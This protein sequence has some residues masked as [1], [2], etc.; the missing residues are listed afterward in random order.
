MLKAQ[1]VALLPNIPPCAAGC[2][3]PFTL[4]QRLTGDVIRNERFQTMHTA[5]YN[6]WCNQNPIFYTA[7]EAERVNAMA[8]Y[9]IQMMNRAAWRGR[10]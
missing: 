10:L 2:G 8:E 5:C 6:Q 7:D 1:I 9:M 3:R 4:H